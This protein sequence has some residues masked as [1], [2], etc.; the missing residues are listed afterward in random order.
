MA[1]SEIGRRKQQELIINYNLRLLPLLLCLLNCVTTWTFWRNYTFLLSNISLRFK[2][3]TS[4]VFCIHK[5]NYDEFILNVRNK[6]Q[7][8]HG[9]VEVIY[10]EIKIFG[11]INVSWQ[12]DSRHVV[13]CIHDSIYTGHNSVCQRSYRI[14]MAV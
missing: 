14:Y 10:R 6:L 8:L 3:N 11:G 13:R 4:D 2:C 1:I 9:I 5:K 12:T 7:T